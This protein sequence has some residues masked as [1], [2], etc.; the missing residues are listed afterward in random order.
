MVA[1]PERSPRKI[2]TIEKVGK[3]L[4]CRYLNGKILFLEI[5]LICLCFDHKGTEPVL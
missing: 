5:S 2:Q 1:F 3:R 4:S